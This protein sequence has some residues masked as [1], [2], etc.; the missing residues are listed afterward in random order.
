[1]LEQEPGGP[2][3]EDHDVIPSCP[4][5]K[6]GGIRPL[7]L[8]EEDLFPGLSQ[9]SNY[10]IVKHQLLVLDEGENDLGKNLPEKDSTEIPFQPPFPL[11][12][13][14]GFIDDLLPRKSGAV[15]KA[16][17]VLLRSNARR[18]ITRDSPL[19]ITPF[20]KED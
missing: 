3:D 8:F 5:S 7:F 14:R 18:P 20:S 12:R 9:I 10:G 15:L 2:P 16:P 4:V 13:E 11:L 1:M 19:P 6:K 17:G